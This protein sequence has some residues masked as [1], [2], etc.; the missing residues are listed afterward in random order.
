MNQ[1]ITYRE[2]DN[3]GVLQYYILQRNF[4]H[5]VGRL[6]S[7]P[8]EGAICQS[9]LPGYNLWIVFSGT[10]NGNFIP[11]FPNEIVNIQLIFDNMAVWFHS[12]RVLMDKKR[13]NKFKI[14][15]DATIT[16]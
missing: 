14:V 8:V 11:S 12:E 1:F 15:S 2:K 5:Y 10:I 7:F 3:E 13:Y 6:S 16:N 9:P 4:P